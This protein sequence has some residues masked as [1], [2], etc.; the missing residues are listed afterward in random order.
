MYL[1]S[2]TTRTHNHLKAALGMTIRKKSTTWHGEHLQK[3]LNED[4]VER[5]VVAGPKGSFMNISLWDSRVW[6]VDVYLLKTLNFAAT[7]HKGRFQLA[8]LWRL[9]ISVD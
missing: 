7:F 5:M 6:T 8:A 9:H 2:S 4:N 1:K 3:N